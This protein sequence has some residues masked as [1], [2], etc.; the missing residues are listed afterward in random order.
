[1]NDQVVLHIG[2]RR[3]LVSP[4]EAFNICNILCGASRI[5]REWISR[6]NNSAWMVSEPD[7]QSAVITPFTTHMML[8]CD[9]NR[10]AKEESK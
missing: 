2:D 9:A 6:E 7:I 4:D 3:F 1:M 10:R 5:T 8:D